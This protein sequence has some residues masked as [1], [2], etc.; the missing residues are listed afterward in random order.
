MTIR[1]RS[2]QSKFNLQTRVFSKPSQQLWS[3]TLSSNLLSPHYQ[4]E[5]QSL[6]MMLR[7][8]ISSCNRIAKE[9]SFL[10]SWTPIE[11]STVA[12][13]PKPTSLGKLI[14]PKCPRIFKAS[15][16]KNRSKEPNRNSFFHL[17]AVK[18]SQSYSS[19]TKLLLR[20]SRKLKRHSIT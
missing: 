18:N 11:R 3:R 13:S 5:T 9:G 14:A 6:L 12:P 8:L 17:I 16:P 7:C 10:S 15:Q 1:L 19:R 4:A 20:V 2:S